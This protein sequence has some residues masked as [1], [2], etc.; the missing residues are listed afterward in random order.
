MGDAAARRQDGEEEIMTQPSPIPT[1]ASPAPAT[2]ITTMPAPPKK[3]SAWASE[4]VARILPQAPAGP[5]TTAPPTITHTQAAG[6]ALG[7]GVTVAMTSSLLGAAHARG[8]LDAGRAAVDG[9]L[10][11]LGLVIGAA[12]APYAPKLSRVSSNIGLSGISVLMFRKSHEAVA[13]QPLGT[14]RPESVVNPSP[15][16]D[17]I[18]KVAREIDL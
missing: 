12:A 2:A 17:L 10:G 9:I 15:G 11:L 8:W 1:T 5:T 6:R 16:E 3:A 7:D 18:A 14:K 4:F 13:G